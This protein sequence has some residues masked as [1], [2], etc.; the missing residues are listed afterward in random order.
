MDSEEILS[1][2]RN[3]AS[4]LEMELEKQ[5]KKAEQEKKR[6]SLGYAMEMHAKSKIQRDLDK[7]Y[8]FFPE[9]KSAKPEQ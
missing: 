5:G 6:D 2:L 8:E 4:D 9:I 7:L 3:Y 1:R